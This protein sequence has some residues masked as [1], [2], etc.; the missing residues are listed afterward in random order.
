MI[1][2]LEK[3]HD[4][5]DTIIT[6]LTEGPLPR[7]DENKQNNPPMYTDWSAVRADL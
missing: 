2:Y 1:Y 7:A 5:K 4:L 6:S 3:I